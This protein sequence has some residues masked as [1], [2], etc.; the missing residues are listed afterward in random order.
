MRRWMVG[1][2]YSYLDRRS[3]SRIA[4]VDRQQ[5]KASAAVKWLCLMFRRPRC[6]SFTR[7]DPH[8]Q[9]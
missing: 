5:S 4:A 6:A 3:G 1:M 2:S 7:N 9:E 8:D